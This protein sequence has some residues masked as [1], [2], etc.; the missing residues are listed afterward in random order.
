MK[1]VIPVML[2]LFLAGCA[3]PAPSTMPKCSKCQTLAAAFPSCECGCD[4]TAAGCLC[5]VLPACS[6]GCKCGIVEGIE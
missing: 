1:R 6:A 5:P 3:G 2:L 4:C